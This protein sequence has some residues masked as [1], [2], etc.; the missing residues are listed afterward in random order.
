MKRSNGQIDIPGLVKEMIEG[1]AHF[2]F[3]PAGALMVRNL[4]ALPGY[5]RDA[6]FACDEKALVRYLRAL[7]ANH[8]RDQAA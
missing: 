6:F 5:L 1:G 4:G 8:A 2:E 3:T 7:D